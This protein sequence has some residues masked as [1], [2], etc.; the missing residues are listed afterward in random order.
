MNNSTTKSGWCLQG[1]RKLK[2]AANEARLRILRRVGML[3]SEWGTGL[4]EEL[5]YW[6]NALKDGGKNWIASEYN[7]R[8]DPNLELQDFLKEL[9]PAKEGSVVRILDVGCGPLTRIG[10]KWQGRTI[11]IHPVDAMGAEYTALLQRLNLRPPVYPQVGH[12][13][14][15]RE[16]FDEGSFDL[17]YASN[18]LDHSYDPL[19]AIRQM[20]EVVRPGC[21]V[22]L[23]HFA[24]VG[25][26]EGYA[27]LHQ[28]N[29]ELQG[30]DVILSDGKRTRHSLREALKDLGR[31]EGSTEKF[32]DID[33]V[34]AKIRKH[35]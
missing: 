34:V 22:Y 26:H 23:W 9:I 24:S 32:F 30:E 29:F 4:P 8:M 15:L 16:Q 20:L 18:S 12:G 33:V 10:R 1:L 2:W 35:S 21:W 19:L 28:W 25:L 11:Q 27:G 31:L 7:E 14:K 17:A 13:E 5:Q 3:G 6:E